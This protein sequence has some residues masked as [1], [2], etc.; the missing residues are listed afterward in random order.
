ML[1]QQAVRV[2]WTLGDGSLLTLMA[3][4]SAAPVAGSAVEGRVL[5]REGEATPQKLAPWTAVFIL[6][7]GGKRG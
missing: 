1:G 7:D 5:W 6:R 2:D 4:L 3:N